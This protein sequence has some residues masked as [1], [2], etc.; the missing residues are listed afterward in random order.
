MESWPVH[1]TCYPCP[2][3]SVLES[4]S[5]PHMLSQPI[6]TQIIMLSVICGSGPLAQIITILHP[7]PDSWCSERAAK[8]RSL[9]ISRARQSGPS[10]SKIST[11]IVATPI[12]SLF[13]LFHIV[14][15]PQR[16]ESCRDHPPL[17]RGRHSR[18]KLLQTYIHPTLPF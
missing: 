14:W 11:E 4:L 10:L 1:R 5:L 16:L 17:Q 18:P 6:H 9:Q 12:T 13:N 15:D 7:N 2:V 3:P 8:N